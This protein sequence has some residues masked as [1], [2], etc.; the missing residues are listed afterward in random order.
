MLIS[1]IILNW[2]RAQLLDLTLRSYA[3]TVSAPYEIIVVDNASTDHSREVIRQARDL[4]PDMKA[5][6]LDNNYG[7]EALNG[8]LTE[9]AGDL[10]HIS[11]NDQL[12]L[13]GWSEHVRDAFLCFDDLGQLSLHGVVPT[14]QEAWEIKPGRLRFSKGKIL[15]EAHDNVGTSSIIR[16]SLIRE[17]N[18]CV[19]NIPSVSASSPKFPDDGKLS[20][21]IKHAGSWCAWSDRY[22]VRNLGHELEEFERDA[23]YY[24]NNYSAKPWLGIEGWQKRVAMAAERRNVIRRSLLFPDEHIQPEKTQNPV[25]AKQSQLWSMF[26]GFTAEVEVLDFLYTL[27]RLIKPTNALETGT[28]LGRSAIA[29]ASAMRDNG[30]GHL[31]TIELNDEVAAVAR[32]RIEKSGLTEFVRIHVG[33]SLA[34]V[35]DQ[36]GYQF[37]LFDSE[38]AIRAAEFGHFYN[39]LEAGAVVVFHDTAEHHVGSA[40]NITKLQEH[41]FVEGLFFETPRGLYVGKVKKTAVA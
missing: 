33:D 23:E 19:R 38:I 1:T 34:F 16:S 40:D 30:F 13:H 29:I 32:R 5:M 15:Y 37:A 3:A 39:H 8:A 17:A 14:D 41:S 11:E 28:W 20:S 26:D 4:L 27:V 6:L 2:N 12:F 9:V 22:Y 35:P 25:G 18:I 36:P 31:Q 21:D 24:R 10:V 7:G